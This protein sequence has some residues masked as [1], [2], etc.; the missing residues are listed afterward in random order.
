MR[1]VI[2]TQN[3]ISVICATRLEELYLIRFPLTAYRVGR[4][5]PAGE[6]PENF[7]W[8]HEHF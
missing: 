5:G 6:S 7:G 8:A 3:P 1:A 2:Q 4:S